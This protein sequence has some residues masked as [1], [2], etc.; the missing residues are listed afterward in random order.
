VNGQ[1]TV[2]PIPTGAITQTQIGPGI[3][4]TP[5][6]ASGVQ[7]SASAGTGYTYAWSTGEMASSIVVQSSA[8]YQ[9]LVTNPQGC[10]TRFTTMVFQQTLIIPNIFSPNGDGIHDRWV[11]ENL[12]NYPGNVVQIYNRYGQAVFKMTNYTPWD[13]RV[14]GK[15]MPVGTYYYIVDPKNGQK[16]TTGY[17]DIIR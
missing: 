5:G 8:G 4:S 7:L 10:S 13:G 16:P 11:I 2:L 3:V 9:V 17:I 12:Q 14:N 15:E 6:I 1:L